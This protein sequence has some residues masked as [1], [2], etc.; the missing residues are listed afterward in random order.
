[1]GWAPS[2]TPDAVG[3]YV[4]DLVVTDSPAPSMSATTTVTIN[5]VNLPPVVVPALATTAWER[6]VG[7]L[8]VSMNVYDENLDTITCTWSVCRAG[9]TPCKPAPAAPAPFTGTLAS[10]A[11]L[12]TSAPF[13]AG[14]VGDDEGDW[15]VRLTCGD[16]IVTPLPFGTTTVTVTNT[17]PTPAVTRPAGY[18]ANLDAAGSTLVTLDASGSTD[19]NG[20]HL[21]APGLS[22]FWEAVSVSDGGALPTLT[23]FDTA[24]PSFTA[25]RAADYILRVTVTDPPSS[26][27]AGASTPLLV[28]VKVGRHIRALAHDVIDSAY[29]KTANKL[30]MAGHDPANAAHG[31]VW[32]LDA[33]TETEGTGILLV[34]TTVVPNVYGVPKYLG[35]TPDGTK[36]VVVDTNVSI[37]FVTLGATPTVTRAVAPFTVQDL[38]VATNRWAYI[39]NVTWDFTLGAFQE[40]DL[41]NNSMAIAPWSGYEGYG[42]A[43]SSGTSNYIYRVET[44]YGDVDKFPIGNNGSAN[45][46]LASGSA[47]CGGYPGTAASAIWPVIADTFVVSSCG[48][49]YRGSDLSTVTGVSLGYPSHMDSIAS[50][51]VAAS[52]STLTLY[53][54][55]LV[56]TGTEIVPAWG[57]TYYGRTASISRVWLNSAGTKRYALV[58]DTASPKRYGL[59]IFP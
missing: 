40:I 9:G 27:R 7:T 49:V 38:V 37:W 57:E 58:D 32:A 44:A 59:V 26:T 34:D 11:T 17:P 21:V 35:V 19:A 16:G 42:A 36:A 41:N 12:S 13:P 22:Y 28:T 4:F 39:F 52:G 3:A 51:A 2:F 6:N 55:T 30:V 47:T 29:A 53:D 56:Q 10:P 23:G 48:V 43:S 20:D 18:Y 31:M 1:L 15:D 50:R 33:A 8:T 5:A 54:A 46:I 25:S 45:T 24:T 14:L